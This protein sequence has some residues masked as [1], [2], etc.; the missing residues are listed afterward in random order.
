MKTGLNRMAR[1]HIHF[2]IGRPGKK[3]VISG[4][5]ASCE[6][7]VEVNMPKAINA[8]FPFYLSKNKVIL[9]AGEK[10]SGALPPEFFRSVVDIKHDK[11]IYSAP[12]DYICVYDFEAQC[13]SG[14]NE[15]TF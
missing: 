2:A 5:R 3:G 8:G 6:V 13:E 10:E 11:L 4:M 14:T 12:F 9:C 7:V 1:N 15:L